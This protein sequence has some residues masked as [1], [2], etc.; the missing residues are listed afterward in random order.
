MTALELSLGDKGYAARMNQR[1]SELAVMIGEIKLDNNTG[2]CPCTVVV[3][4]PDGTS[5][6]TCLTADDCN[7]LG[8]IIITVLLL[9]LIY[10]FLDWLF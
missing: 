7:S 4:N 8:T 6:T 2:I 10:E 1:A 9:W 3:T 5:Q